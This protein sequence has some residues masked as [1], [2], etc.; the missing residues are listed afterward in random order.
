MKIGFSLDPQ[1]K[2]EKIS[3]FLVGII[4]FLLLVIFSIIAYRKMVIIFWAIVG[5]ALIIGVVW[6]YFKIKYYFKEKK[7]D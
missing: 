6:S 1:T 4:V 3:K 7:H 2:L 5:T